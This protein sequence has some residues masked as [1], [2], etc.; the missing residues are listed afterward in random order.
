MVLT[1]PVMFI[2]EKPQIP[3]LLAAAVPILYTGVCSCGIAYTLQIV[4]QK[5]ASPTAATVLMSM[6]SVFAM[7][8]GVWL[9]HQVP[10]VRE[11]LG[12]LMILA[13]V[14]LIQL[15]AGKHLRVLRSEQDGI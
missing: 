5:Y 2:L 1:A 8:G 12:C 14:I 4:G 15:P 3:D 7:I 9:L 6:E 10:T 13:A 11:L